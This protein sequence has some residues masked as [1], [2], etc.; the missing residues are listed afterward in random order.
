MG[1]TIGIQP[2]Y[3]IN[4]NDRDITGA[5]AKDLISLSITDEAGIKSDSL[6]IQLADN[7]PGY[8]LPKTGA[9]LEVW[10]GYDGKAQNK[11][12][13]IV[14]E[15]E[16]SGPPSAIIIKAQAAP[17]SQQSDRLGQIQTQKNRSWENITLGDLTKTIAN[18]HGMAPVVARE[19]DNIKLPHIDQ[20]SESDINLLTRITKDYG[21]L[22]KPVSGR[23]L[24]VEKGKSKTASGKELAP[25]ELMPEDITSWKV[26]MA[27]RSKYASVSTRW[28]DLD[29]GQE[30]TVTAGEGKPTLK[31]THAYSDQSA[32]EAA[33]KA[34]YEA[35]QRGASRLSITCPGSPELI[36]E[37]KLT[38]H[39][40]RT[41]VDGDWVISRVSH[42]LDGKG[43]S[44]SVEGETVKK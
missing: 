4:A 40:F 23:L 24:V 27:D 22:V 18:E 29:S 3:R 32:A 10:L 8:A 28:N 25:I 39:G 5:L 16:L 36:A 26:R 21:A 31:I 14:N 42:K 13:F 9:K 37:G 33:A 11:G 12:I 38:L 6:Q 15:L 35:L 43:Y 7:A 34:R 1:L 19:L 44:C 2:V 41:G 30:K 17:L 20:T